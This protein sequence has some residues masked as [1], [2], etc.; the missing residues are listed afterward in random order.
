MLNAAASGKW[1]GAVVTAVSFCSLS[2]SN[3]ELELSF[4]FTYSRLGETYSIL[5][6]RKC[7]IIINGVKCEHLFTHTHYDE[8][9]HGHF[10]DSRPS[11]RLFGY[12]LMAMSRLLKMMNGH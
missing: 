2:L 12:F 7:T 9:R 8:S 5:S 4:L 11:S 3:A 10:G 6:Y 1:C